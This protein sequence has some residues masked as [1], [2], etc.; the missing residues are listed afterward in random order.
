MR[1]W[2]L[3]LGDL[4]GLVG[5]QDFGDDLVDAELGGDALGGRPAV[6]GEHDRPDPE[7]AERADGRGGG[8]AR[9]VGD[10]DHGRG[11]VVDRDLHARAALTRQLVRAGGQ[12]VT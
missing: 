9:G 3:E 2:L 5:G 1:P 12:A 10:G 7:F 8:L 4:G 6:A 11:L